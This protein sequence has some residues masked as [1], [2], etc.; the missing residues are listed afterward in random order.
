MQ[1][2]K[3]D[4]DRTNILYAKYEYMEEFAAQGAPVCKLVVHHLMRQIPAN[5]EACEETSYGQHY[6]SGEKVEDVEQR[7]AANLQSV[8]FAQR[9]RAYRADNRAG[10]S[11]DESGTLTGGV[12]LL[13]DECRAHLMKRYER[14]QRG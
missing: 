12:K 9:Q 2:Y 10:Q 4:A 13:M 8:P 7:T 6:L 5:K 3:K 14:R 1:E 11:D